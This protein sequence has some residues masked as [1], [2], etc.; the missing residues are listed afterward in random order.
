M[1][2]T[3]FRFKCYNKLTVK[4]FDY[5]QLTL[6]NGRSGLGKSTLFEAILWCLYGGMQHIYPSDNIGNK[7]P[8]YV[9]LEFQDIRIR[10]SQPPCL[11]ELSLK[12]TTL[13][14]V[15]AQSYIDLMFGKK[16]FFITSSYIQQN[17]RSPLIT[18]SNSE[19]TQLLHELTFGSVS[20]S[21]NPELYITRLDQ[22]LSNLKTQIATDTANYNLLSQQ[23][24]SSFTQ[25]QEKYQLW[26]N[27]KSSI[28]EINQLK[29]Q[30]TNKLKQL[31]QSHNLAVVKQTK[32]NLLT[33]QIQKI[34]LVPPSPI[35][36]DSDRR[37]IELEQL[38][39]SA[40]SQESI[41]TEIGS[42]KKQLDKFDPS[43]NSDQI[44]TMKEEITKS[45][46]SN[47][48]AKRFN[49]T[50]ADKDPLISKLKSQLVLID[51][52]I[53]EHQ[54]WLE[55]KDQLIKNYDS[56]IALIDQEVIQTN[57]ELKEKYQTEKALYDLNQ[58][59]Q[60]KYEQYLKD[61]TRYNKL[62]EDHQALVNDLKSV[63]KIEEKYL[64][65]NPNRTDLLTIDIKT[66][67]ASIRELQSLKNQLHCPHCN[68]DLI[69]SNGKLLIGV[70][71]VETDYDNKIAQLNQYIEII[72]I[73]REKT[74]Q[75]NMI[76]IDQPPVVITQP[77]KLD[78]PVYNPIKG[79]YPAKPIIPKEPLVNHD[80]QLI[81]SNIEQLS[82][83]VQYDPNYIKL[84]KEKVETATLLPHFKSLYDRL[85]YLE[86]QVIDT[87]ESNISSLEL[88]R[89]QL[90]QE[91]A[92]NYS[93]TEQYRK[94]LI[95]IETITTEID[96]I[97]YDLQE[98]SKL[99]LEKETNT[100]ELNRLKELI[101]A[102]QF[103]ETFEKQRNIVETH[104]TN[105]LK[106]IEYE[107]NV[108]KLKTII[109][110]I[111]S[112]AMEETIQAIN[113]VTN[114]ILK[115]IFESDIQVILKTHKDLK[116]KEKVKLQVNLQVTYR[117]CVYDSPSRL[118]GGEQD[119]I[120]M[121]LTLAIAKVNS[122]PIL[123]LDECMSSLD[124]DLQE[125]C[126]ESITEFLPN[127]SILHICHGA[128]KGQH[129][130]TLELN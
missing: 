56:E 43:V 26:I 9:I 89:K 18:A 11:I 64:W 71:T 50:V 59:E 95:R 73:V 126:L 101:L 99:K 13:T 51:Q 70:V 16:D 111:T 27:Q 120:S 32:H 107:S 79:S 12:A 74:S 5:N 116:T 92:I 113:Y 44:D 23:L 108:L 130:R 8:T 49:I 24:N 98:L 28:K 115:K 6:I 85:N 123:L 91:I 55:L 67:E 46:E 112:Q 82:L 84:I 96:Q 17:N 83:M 93:Q 21:E 80:R 54:Q 117:S 65:Y 129:G 15:E 105:L 86:S 2:L 52:S 41:K 25:G 61:L 19:K 119:R 33:D 72:K 127:K 94:D 78:L 122:S 31:D 100:V 40:K 118:S 110:E 45:I 106:Y 30:V 103:F 7:E 36:K 48:I 104:K 66:I 60:L 77:I 14:G 128:T 3:L 22:E 35:N 58:K 121:A 62:K 39:A 109:Q 88:E 124:Q 102:H 34:K 20:E 90:N 42:L 75:L 68:G 29:D 47:M 53:I 97:G 4:E 114:E 87:I 38:I 63:N 81:E 37:L 69:Y 1:K 125:L 76:N 10:R 57:K